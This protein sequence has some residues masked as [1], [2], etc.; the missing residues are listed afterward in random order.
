MVRQNKL[1]GVHGNP[2]S[3]GSEPLLIRRRKGETAGVIRLRDLEQFSFFDR[4][5]NPMARVHVAHGRMWIRQP[6]DLVRP[7]R[8]HEDGKRIFPAPVRG[9]KKIAEQ[10]EGGRRRVRWNTP[11][12]QGTRRMR[13]LIVIQ[14]ADQ[15]KRGATRSRQQ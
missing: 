6:V 11:V 13:V 2:F 5:A 9:R 4:Q 10:P 15:F 12:L 7:G 14:P 1:I 3:T 8:I